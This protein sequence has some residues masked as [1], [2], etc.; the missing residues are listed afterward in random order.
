MHVFCTF[1]VEQKGWGVVCRM[2]SL[3]VV[4]VVG[5]G[6]LVLFVLVDFVVLN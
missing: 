3:V 2:Y 4:I 1:V 5:E 6:G